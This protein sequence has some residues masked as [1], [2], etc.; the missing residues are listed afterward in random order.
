[1]MRWM[2]GLALAAPLAAA[3]AQPQPVAAGAATRAWLELQR[4]GNAALGAPRPMSGE[5]ADK[6]YARYLNS[7]TAPIPQAFSREQFLTG[8]GGSNR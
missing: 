8:S 4:G 3:A 7:F 5:V 1:M 6:V 2:I